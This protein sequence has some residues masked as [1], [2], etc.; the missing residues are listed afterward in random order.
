MRATT[1]MLCACEKRNVR[2][3]PMPFVIFVF[4]YT[5][6]DR[7]LSK[8]LSYLESANAAVPGSVTAAASPATAALRLDNRSGT[9]ASQPLTLATIMNNAATRI[10]DQAAI[11]ARC[12]QFS[13]IWSHQLF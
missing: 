10:C 3:C 4:S 5:H 7:Q 8:A 13:T 12:R 1:T 9:G 11:S 6:F 2:T